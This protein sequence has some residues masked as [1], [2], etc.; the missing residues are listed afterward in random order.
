MTDQTAAALGLAGAVCIAL[1]VWGL[2]RRLGRPLPDP[3]VDPFG[4]GVDAASSAT[5]ALAFA[6]VVWACVTVLWAPGDAPRAREGLQ[7]TLSVMTALTVAAM[8][9]YQVYLAVRHVDA[10]DARLAEQRRADARDDR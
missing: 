1:G 6:Q 5:F 4:F 3:R 8:V 9:A 10:E 7:D 2:Q